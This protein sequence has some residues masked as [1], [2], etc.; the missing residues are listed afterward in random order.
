MK[1]PIFSN[2]FSEFDYNLIMDTVK[3]KTVDFY[4]L[5]NKTKPKVMY[6]VS[7]NEETRKLKHKLFD[8]HMISLVKGMNQ[9]DNNGIEIL[10]V[11][12]DIKILD[13]KDDFQ[14]TDIENIDHKYYDIIE[15]Y[16]IDNNNENIKHISKNTTL[17]IL[18][19]I[20]DNIELMQHYGRDNRCQ[21]EF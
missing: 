11:K 7:L 9:S 19:T 8:E 6:N 20:I 16:T 3:N 13:I 18:N 14:T 10:A 4:K 1:V 17:D 5:G 12:D 2:L 15:C 21:I